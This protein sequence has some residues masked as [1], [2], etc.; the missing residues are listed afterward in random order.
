VAGGYQVAPGRGLPDFA[1]QVVP[2]YAV[3]FEG[4]KF[5]MG[6]TSAVAPMWAALAARLNQRIGHSIGFFA[7]LL[8]GTAADSIF[9]DVTVGGNDRYHCTAGWNPCAG[10]GVPIGSAIE[11][12]LGG[13][14]S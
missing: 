8:Y 3:F 9:R 6:G 14:G 4:T 10:L 12:A 1:A 2:G 13:S 5:A 11:R 7:P